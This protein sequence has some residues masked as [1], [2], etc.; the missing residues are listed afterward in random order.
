M[1]KLLSIVLVL[2]LA[3]GCMS[4]TVAEDE[5]PTLKLLVSWGESYPT[6]DNPILDRLGEIVGCKFSVAKAEEHE[7]VSR[8]I[9]ELG[10]R[11][12]R[13]G[14]GAKLKNGP[15]AYTCVIKPE[16]VR[17]LDG[18]FGSEAGRTFLADMEKLGV[19]PEGDFGRDRAER[20]APAEGDP[21]A[22]RTVVITGTFHD[23]KRRDLTQLL[24]DRGAKVT[25]SVSKTT[26]LLAVGDGPGADKTAAA[27]RFGTPTMD[28]AAL[29]A[30]LGL[31]PV[32]MQ[33]SLF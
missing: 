26:D 27:R 25:S 2:T 17:A 5:L 33:D 23:L 12:L 16:A 9:E 11:L 24:Q 32:V 29:R 18:F 31:P 8:E 19:N 30:A 10:E 20:P 3:L 21:F 7:R 4:I 22:G 14:V 1:K 15:L 28:E 6:E 13:E